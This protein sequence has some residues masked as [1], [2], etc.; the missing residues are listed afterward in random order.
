MQETIGLA[1]R[2]PPTDPEERSPLPHMVSGQNLWDGSIRRPVAVVRPAPARPKSGVAFSCLRA[3]GCLAWPGLPLPLHWHGMCC[4]IS[5][6]FLRCCR[7]A[8]L[9]WRATTAALHIDPVQLQRPRNL[10]NRDVLAHILTQ[11]IQYKDRHETELSF[12]FFLSLEW[13][14]EISPSHVDLLHVNTRVY[15]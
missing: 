13:H 1:G 11:E 8:S 10:C 3:P 12:V 6:L 7:A 5:Q 4:G 2:P 14:G 15:I 9:A